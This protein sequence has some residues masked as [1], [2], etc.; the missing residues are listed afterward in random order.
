MRTEYATRGGVITHIIGDEAF[1][2]IKPQLSKREIKF[3]TCIAKK[4]VP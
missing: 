4:H 1:E 2:F 3:T